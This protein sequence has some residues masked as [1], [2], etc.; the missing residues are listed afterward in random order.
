MSSSI[1]VV[2]RFT[3]RTFK[4]FKQPPQ[5]EVRTML[6]SLFSAISG[7][8]SNQTFMDIVGNNIS[9]VNTTGF[10]AA[11]IT[12]EDLLSQTVRGGTAPDQQHGG[13]NPAQV[14]LGVQVA[15][16]GMSTAQGNLEATGSP[17]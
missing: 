2:R 8:R 1:W 11:R 10:K 7:L 16:I 9:N 5:T 3:S 13:I 15:S 14:G 12:F 4:K 17:T 6:R